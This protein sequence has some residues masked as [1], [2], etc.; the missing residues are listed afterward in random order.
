MARSQWII[1]RADSTC[2]RVFHPDRKTAEGHRIAL[3]FWIKATGRA[4]EGRRLVVFRC[5]RCGGFHIANRKVAAEVAR[6]EPSDRP[7]PA[8][9]DWARI[10][11]ELDVQETF[12]DIDLE[13][14]S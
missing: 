5:R 1:P 11:L 7:F 6:V 4:R 3:E 13:A 8:E 12:T 9:R 14:V 2:G 10:N